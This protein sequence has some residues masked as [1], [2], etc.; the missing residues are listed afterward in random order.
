MTLNIYF[1]V[2]S[3]F[4][5]CNHIT[6]FQ[7]LLYPVFDYMIFQEIVTAKFDN[8][9]GIL[10]SSL[11]CTWFQQNFV[12]Y[13]NYFQDLP[14]LGS[15]VF[16]LGIAW[17]M[18][19]SGIGGSSFFSV[20]INLLCLTHGSICLCWLKRI[21]KTISSFQIPTNTQIEVSSNVKKQRRDF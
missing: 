2:K 18:L 14:S 13:F 5:I 21:P 7:R 11:K 19:M 4:S 1:T 16:R 3:I 15:K 12:T 9:S 8:K 6:S 17:N 20:L 10:H